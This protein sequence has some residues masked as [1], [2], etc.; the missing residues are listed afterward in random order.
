MQSA[1]GKEIFFSPSA[2]HCPKP[3]HFP[4]ARGSY[5]DL[6]MGELDEQAKFKGPYRPKNF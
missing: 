4:I 5:A 6:A 2:F 3:S 1:I